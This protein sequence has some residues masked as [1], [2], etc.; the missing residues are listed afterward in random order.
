MECAARDHAT[1]VGFQGFRASSQKVLCR[2]MD[3]GILGAS[4]LGGS[5]WEEDGET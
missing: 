3:S 4:L 5:A 2:G 1:L